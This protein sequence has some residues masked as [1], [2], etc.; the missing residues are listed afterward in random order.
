M[1]D[2]GACEVRYVCQSGQSRS[3]SGKEQGNSGN[4]W[5]VYPVLDSDDRLH[6]DRLQRLA[7]AFKETGADFIQTGFDPDTNETVEVHFGRLKEDLIS[8]ALMGV[9]WANTLRSAYKHSLVKEIGLWNTEMTCFEDNEYVIRALIASGKSV[10]IRDVLASARRG[11]GERISDRLRTYKGRGH[12]IHCEELV[13]K[14]AKQPSCVLSDSVKNHFLARIYNLGVR[15]YA[16][17]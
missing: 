11:G 2:K 15:T 7:D 13:L 9:L 16:S 3:W 12:R 8:Q 1:L 10:A 5:G 17:G 4:F 14:L 6:P